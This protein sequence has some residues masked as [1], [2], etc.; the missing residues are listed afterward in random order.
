MPSEKFQHVA[1]TSSTARHHCQNGRIQTAIHVFL[2]EVKDFNLSSPCSALTMNFSVTINPHVCITILYIPPKVCHVFYCAQ[3]PNW[4]STLWNY[5]RMCN[6]PDRCLQ[7]VLSRI[8]KLYTV[9]FNG[10][11]KLCACSPIFRTT[12]SLVGWKFQV[13]AA[14]SVYAIPVLVNFLTNEICRA[15]Q[16]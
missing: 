5:S 14:D 7:D 4:S 8:R 10:D 1:C 6:A 9:S 12:H 16:T 3:K 2:H 15:I 11:N 13:L